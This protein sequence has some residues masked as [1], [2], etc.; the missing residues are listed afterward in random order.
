MQN[1]YDLGQGSIVKHMVRLAVP[2]IVANII[3]AL[4]NI[5][6]RMYIGR[7]DTTGYSI[8][9]LGITFPIITAVAAFAS[10][11]GMGGSPKAS[12]ALGAK[13]EKYASKVL[14]N[15]VLMLLAFS[16]VLTIVFTLVKTPLLYAFGGSDN[17][18]PFAND[19]LSIYL[20]G[21]V[22]VQLTMGLNPFISAQGLS[23]LSMS[24]II[25][26]AGLNIILDPIFI[27]GLDM[28]VKGAAI[29]TVISQAVSASYVIYT[30]TKG[31]KSKL[32]IKLKK[33]IPDKA[34][35]LGIVS[36][37]V[38][39]F[40]MQMTESFVTIVLNTTL[41]KFGGDMYVGAMTILASIF[42]FALM[43]ISGLG[44]G[45]G[46]LISYNYGARKLDRVK[47]T[48]KLII[49][50]SFALAIVT[51]V[52][53]MTFPQMFIGI[54]T[55][56]KELIDLASR[57]LRI[58]ISGVCI[59]GLQFAVQPVF[60]SL[61][62]PKVS[63]FLAV[64]RKV[65]LIIPLAFILPRIGLGAEGVFWAEPISDI[66][67]ATTAI[68]LFWHFIPKIMKKASESEVAQ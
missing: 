44:Y 49:I 68:C 15:S 17:T 10:L 28:G 31:K 38:S 26:G 36:L 16:V 5:V 1:K 55:K 39:S 30:L 9:G 57:M 51:T 7:M 65:I 53:I 45:S 4:Y 21:T 40:I 13:D 29:A 52:V 22:F 32:K 35:M 25:I 48:Y 46:P 61:N 50:I 60:I 18:V 11:V 59:L 66:L 43:P 19:Y 62:Q 2:T 12:I 8:T 33:M 42:Q 34:I 47:R 14:N 64:L 37:G 58:Y 20:M 63:I 6:D 56:E 23:M 24:T 3:N 67:S 54:F 27:F 41:Q